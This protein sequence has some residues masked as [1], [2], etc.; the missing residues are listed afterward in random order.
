MVRDRTRG[1]LELFRVAPITPGEILIGKYLGFL[2]FLAVLAVALIAL[3]VFGL[4]VPLVGDYLWLALSVLLLLF[5]SLGLGF[6]LSMIST[7]E[8]QA[9][10]LAM[11]TLLTSVFFSGF[12]L[13]LENFWEPV[14]NL[15]YVLP[16]THGIVMLQDVMLRGRAP[17]WFYLGTLLGLGVLFAAFSMWRFGREFRRG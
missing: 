7:T 8:S 5:A 9:V 11:L 1:A 16:V 4:G 12:F 6:A 17:D 2:I 14:A 15:A 13:A 10:Q 3:S